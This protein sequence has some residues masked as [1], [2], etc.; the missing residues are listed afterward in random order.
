MQL[1]QLNITPFSKP[2]NPAKPLSSHQ[3]EIPGHADEKNSK[4]S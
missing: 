4:I 2:R 3:E 1:T